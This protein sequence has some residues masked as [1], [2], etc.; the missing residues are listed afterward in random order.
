MPLQGPGDWDAALHPLG[1]VC[2]GGRGWRVIQCQSLAGEGWAV[3]LRLS[4]TA[5]HL[6]LSP[7]WGRRVARETWGQTPPCSKPLVPTQ[8][9][10]P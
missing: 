4:G 5:G 2:R 6:P 10:I 1:P 7:Q 8:L 9:P 3:S